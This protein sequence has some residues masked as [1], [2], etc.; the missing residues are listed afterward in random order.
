MEWIYDD[1]NAA[2]DNCFNLNKTFNGTKKLAFVFH[3]TSYKLA[4][5]SPNGTYELLTSQQIGFNQGSYLLTTNFHSQEN[6][7][8]H[9]MALT[10]MLRSIKENE[11]SSLQTHLRFAALKPINGNT[12]FTTILI[13]FYPK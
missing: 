13:S 11:S 6:Y 3:V 9:A 12:I 2:F 10:S 1:L 5:V 8:F 7:H 4:Y